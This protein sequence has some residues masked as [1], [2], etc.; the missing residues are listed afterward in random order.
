MA[1]QHFDFLH[2]HL[3]HHNHNDQHEILQ[4]AAKL[5]ILWKLSH[6][7]LH[8]AQ[9]LHPEMQTIKINLLY[10]IFVGYVMKQNVFLGFLILQTQYHIKTVRLPA[11]FRWTVTITI[12][13]LYLQYF[14]KPHNPELI[15]CSE[16][17]IDMTNGRR[18]S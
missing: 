13:A 1:Q 5:T 12:F 8:F 18:K 11:Q 10:I 6:H 17:C 4:H 9:Q 3:Q 15:Y 2:D 14:I 16:V 7:L